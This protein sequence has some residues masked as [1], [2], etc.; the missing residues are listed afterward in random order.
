MSGEKK[1]A[2]FQMMMSPSEV[3]AID[4][5]KFANRKQSRAEAIRALIQIALTEELRKRGEAA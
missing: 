2:K 3:K 5:W 4:D 1:T